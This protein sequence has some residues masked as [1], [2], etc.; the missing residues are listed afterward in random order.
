MRPTATTTATT[1][2][3]R[4]LLNAAL[5]FS[6]GLPAEPFDWPDSSSGSTAERR[7]T[8][9]SSS[10]A[11]QR[12]AELRPASVRQPMHA[13]MSVKASSIRA[14]TASAKSAVNCFDTVY[15]PCLDATV[16][17]PYG[18]YVHG[19]DDTAGALSGIQKITGALR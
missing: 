16:G 8:V 6:P 5:T 1:E 9:Y 11:R 15:Y 13:P 19:N 18:V 12:Y 10:C 14:M 3:D 7:L 17:L 2:D 4:S